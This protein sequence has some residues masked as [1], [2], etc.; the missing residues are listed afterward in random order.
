MSLSVGDRPFVQ[1]HVRDLRFLEAGT[2]VL[3]CLAHFKLRLYRMLG[4]QITD[5]A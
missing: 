3:A 5:L 2:G 1:T 4:V